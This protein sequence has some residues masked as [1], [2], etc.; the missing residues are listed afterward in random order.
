[1]IED[2]ASLSSRRREMELADV[3][4][5]EV[6]RRFIQR[7][8]GLGDIG[9]ASAASADFMIRMFD[10]PDPERVA[11]TLRQARLKRLASAPALVAFRPM[12]IATQNVFHPGKILAM[13]SANALH[14]TPSPHNHLSGVEHATDRHATHRIREGS[15]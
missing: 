12:R 1:M 5:I 6:N 4:S 9:I 2:A 14:S 11:E 10:I 15:G 7:A 8:I 13:I 3:R